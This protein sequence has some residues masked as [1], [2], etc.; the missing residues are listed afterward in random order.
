M[1]QCRVETRKSEISGKYTVNDA[2]IGCAIC[3]EIAPENFRFN[4]EQECEY[5]CK[6]PGT[7]EEVCLCVVV[8]YICP[9]NYIEV[10]GEK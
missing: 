5:V 1:L 2:C 7:E 9:V 10:A 6:Q 4:H 8:I 3:S